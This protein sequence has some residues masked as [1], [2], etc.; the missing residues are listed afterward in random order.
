MRGM[1][2]ILLCSI[3]MSS[4]CNLGLS[5]GKRRGM[6]HIRVIWYNYIVT[7]LI[8]SATLALFG[9]PGGGFSLSALA[10][11]QTCRT[12]DGLFT[13]TWMVGMVSGVLYLVTFLI[14]QRCIVQAGPG[15]S[16][17]ISK[18]GVVITALLTAPLWRERLTP[19]RLAGILLACAALFLVHEGGLVFRRA[20][21]LLFLSNGVN[22]IMKKVYTFYGDIAYQYLYYWII[23]LVCLILSS[24]IVLVTRRGG[25]LSSGELAVGSTVG[26][27]NMGATYAMTWALT[28][29]P[30]SIAFPTQCGGVILFTSAVGALRY[31]ESFSRV[32]A[33]G[34]LMTIVSIVL[35]NL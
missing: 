4:V 13:F 29:I 10:Q 7:F 15:M 22:E 3:L 20:L 18:L 1:D 5:E 2:G 8:S 34:L 23:F 35:M 33:V 6:D 16:T 12:P 9:A 17:L 32:K 24:G 26:L 28:G 19:V 30:A 11:L 27:C 31:G 14:L 21:P 25:R